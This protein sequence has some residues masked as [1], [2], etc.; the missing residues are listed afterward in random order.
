V[1]ATYHKCVNVCRKDNSAGEQLCLF[2]W[3]RLD[4]KKISES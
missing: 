4:W 2:P 3:L 1:R